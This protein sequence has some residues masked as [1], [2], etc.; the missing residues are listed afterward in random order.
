ML[1]ASLGIGADDQVV[2][3]TLSCMNNLEWGIVGALCG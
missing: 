2:E 1:K 3:G